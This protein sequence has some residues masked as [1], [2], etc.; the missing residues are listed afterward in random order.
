MEQL[1]EQLHD[2]L[3]KE[4]RAIVVFQPKRSYKIVPHPPKLFFGG[5]GGAY[6]QFAKN[7]TAV[8]IYDRYAEIFCKFQTQRRLPNGSRSSDDNQCLQLLN[9]NSEYLSIT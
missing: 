8:G 5:C 3:L 4:G 9:F 7:L 1:T 2:L 6:F